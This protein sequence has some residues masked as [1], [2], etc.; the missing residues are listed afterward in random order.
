MSEDSIYQ[1][2]RGHL[3]SLRLAAAA[4]ALPPSSN[5]PRR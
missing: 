2:L 1:V 5:T 3:A 4:E